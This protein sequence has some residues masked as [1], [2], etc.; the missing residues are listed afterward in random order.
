M[1][2][3]LKKNKVV[4]IIFVFS[5]S[6]IIL[7]LFFFLTDYIAEKE[8]KWG[9]ICYSSLSN[10]KWLEFWGTFMPALAAFSFLYFTKKQIDSIREQLDFE[11]TKYE[12]EINSNKEALKIEKEKYKKEKNI[13]IFEKNV[14]LELNELKLSRMIVHNLLIEL[15]IADIDSCIE[16]P[17]KYSRK[18][19]KINSKLTAVDFLTNIRIQ[20]II[21]I[22]KQIDECR[23]ES[24]EKL[25]KL[26]ELYTIILKESYNNKYNKEDEMD[27]EK[28]FIVLNEI[29]KLQG[30]DLF[31]ITDFIDEIT[32]AKLYNE[33][34]NIT[35]NALLKYFYLKNDKMKYERIVIYNKEE[36]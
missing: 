9:E 15:D 7:N 14:E 19:K 16:T 17:E 36:I 6:P 11:K 29:R 20:D 4:I 5:I 3:F 33:F 32:I 34:Y 18:I 10:E 21:K 8:V 25:K 12:E 35:L 13:L 28:F 1:I 27:K 30:K 23:E 2:K 22:D 31:K 24:Y 26:H